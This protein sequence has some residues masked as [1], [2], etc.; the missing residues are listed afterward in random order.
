MLRPRII[1]CLLIHKNGLTKTINF[2]QHKYLGDP[3]N[4]IRI[5]N[6]KEA[7]ELFVADID[8]TAYGRE[9]DYMLIEKLASECRM[10]FCYAGGI[11]TV[12]QAERIINLGVEKI[13]ISSAA[14]EN[15]NLITEISQRLGNQSVVVVFDV[16][17]VGLFKSY[18]IFTHNGMQSSGLNPIE[19]SKKIEKLGAGEILINSIDCDGIMNGYDLELV[20]NIRKSINLP[21]SVLGGAGS[22]EHIKA[23]IKMNGVIGACVG[24]FFVF[25][26][27]YKAVLIQYPSRAEKDTILS[28]LK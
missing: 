5:F 9:P 4:A 11:K 23:L 21:L 14:I 20:K 12:E 28:E 15:P 7:D 18:E 10:P 8:A 17:K 3:L 25:K 2:S 13:G 19:F 1:P 16:K 6:E 26:G 24:S 27:K 22:Y